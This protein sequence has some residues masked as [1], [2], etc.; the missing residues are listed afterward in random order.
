[1]ILLDSSILIELFR[2]QKKETTAFYKLAQTESDFCISAVSHYEI[3]LGNKKSYSQF[4]DELLSNLPVIPFDKACSATAIEIFLNL[5][6]KNKIIDIA[7]IWIAATAKTHNFKIATLNQKHF[8]R[9]PGL[10]IIK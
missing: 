9:I 6:K 7:D 3:G 5:K 8:S 10:E 2:K 4:W 1:M